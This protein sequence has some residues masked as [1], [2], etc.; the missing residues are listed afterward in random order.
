MEE[1]SVEERLGTVVIEFIAIIKYT[2][3]DAIDCP[4]RSRKR[5]IWRSDVIYLFHDVEDRAI[6]FTEN[7]FGRNIS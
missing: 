1:N 6:M 7:R 3:L 5:V 2:L 4:L